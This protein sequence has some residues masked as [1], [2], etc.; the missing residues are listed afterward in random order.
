MNNEKIFDPGTIQLMGILAAWAAFFLNFYFNSF[1]KRSRIILTMEFNP[2][3]NYDN[4]NIRI[5]NV[6]ERVA[7]HIQ[8]SIIP[9]I[10]EYDKEKNIFLY[11]EKHEEINR[12]CG[13]LEIN[14][15]IVIPAMIANDVMRILKNGNNFSGKASPI[16]DRHHIVVKINYSD[17]LPFYFK[18]YY[19]NKLLL[20]LNPYNPIILRK[21]DN[22]QLDKINVLRVRNGLSLLQEKYFLIKSSNSIFNLLK[23]LWEKIK[24]KK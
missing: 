5:N 20:C 3:N 16:D 21:V 10:L 15:T 22:G 18:R 24:I 12:I 9:T 7:S 11:K 17:K 2:E 13:D 14:E 19:E 4:L 8:V 23:L 1:S 6:G